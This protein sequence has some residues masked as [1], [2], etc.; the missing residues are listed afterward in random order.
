MSLETIRCFLRANKLKTVGFE[1][2]VESIRA[3]KQ[4]RAMSQMSIKPF[5]IWK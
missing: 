4:D 3:E 2:V 5:F 1:K